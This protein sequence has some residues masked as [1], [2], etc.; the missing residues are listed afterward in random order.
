MPQMAPLWWLSL[1]MM[2]I[3]CL[4]MMTT[5]IYFYKKTILNQNKINNKISF[6]W[7]W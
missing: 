6:K 7:T 3:L 4:I 2:F 5:N 1:E